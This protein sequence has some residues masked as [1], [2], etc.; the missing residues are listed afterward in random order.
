MDLILSFESVN[1][2]KSKPPPLGGHFRANPPTKVGFNSS[3][4]SKFKLKFQLKMDLFFNLRKKSFDLF[5]QLKMPLK[6]N[7]VKKKSTIKEVLI[8]LVFL[9]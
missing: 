9:R 1:F 6:S 5:F 3:F 4:C 7:L 2:S 8:Y